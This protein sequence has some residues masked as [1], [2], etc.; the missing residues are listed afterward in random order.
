MHDLRATYATILL[1]NNYGPKVVS[2]LMGH[3]KEI[4]KK[5]Y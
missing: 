5:V 3:A 1:K 4:Y 2:K